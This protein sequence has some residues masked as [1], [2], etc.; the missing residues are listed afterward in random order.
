MDLD[1]ALVL[2]GLHSLEQADAQ[3]TLG[4]ADGAH[5][6]VGGRVDAGAGQ[7]G[8]D[9]VL[10]H[11]DAGHGHVGAVGGGAVLR[12]DR[13]GLVVQEPRAAR[14]HG[15]QVGGHGG[16]ALGHGPVDRHDVSGQGVVQGDQVGQRL[17]PG[18]GLTAEGDDVGLASAQ[19][20]SDGGRGAGGLRVHVHGSGV[21][22][23][24]DGVVGGL[25]TIT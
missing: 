14:G 16:Q 1:D 10:G 21:L 25:G 19:A 9:G 2:A 15:E 13:C 17:A 6:G 23:C 22:R 7:R 12:G 24:C 3:D 20:L 8:Q 11:E 18:G 4:V 5:R